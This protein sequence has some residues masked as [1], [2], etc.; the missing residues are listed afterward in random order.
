MGSQYKLI[1]LLLVSTFL[2]GSCTYT[3]PVELV[4]P[5]ETP[6]ETITP[7]PSQLLREISL[8][9]AIAPGMQLSPLYAAISNGYFNQRG[10]GISLESGAEGDSM[11][12]LGKNQ[13]QFAIASSEYVLQARATGLPVVYVMAWYQKYPIEVVSKKE[14]NINSPQ[15]LSG[16]VV[17]LPGLFGSYMVGLDALL[18]AGQLKPSNLK[19]VSIG[20]TQ[21]DALK[22]DRVQAVVANT[23][24]LAQ[25]QSQFPVS[26][27]SV[28]DFA[29]VPSYG[30]V[31]NEKTLQE[32]PELVQ[33][34]VDAFQ[35]G[36][37]YTMA[38]SY[39]SFKITLRYV[40]TL[41]EENFD[42][43]YAILDKAIDQWTPEKMKIGAS[44]PES[45]KNMQD[46]M[47]TWGLLNAPVDLEKAYTN[48]FIK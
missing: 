7:T 41:E 6:E 1:R 36:I 8:P 34:M 9:V 28:S 21:M 24:D 5:E 47:L 29:Q 31:T 25:L 27:I 44:D 30:L 11:V 16:K 2:L 3:P 37:D 22:N 35:E 45:W 12:R 19:L 43:Q 38:R 23:F 4:N 32:E 18:S 17:G 39:D 42:I 20:F 13:I 40:K 15:D 33:K 26:V 46:L 48:Q 10:L 14:L